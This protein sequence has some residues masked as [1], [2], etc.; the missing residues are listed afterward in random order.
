MSDDLISVPLPSLIHKIGRE[1]AAELRQLAANFG[2]ECKRI[3]RSRNWQLQ[4]DFHGLRSLLDEL[5]VRDSLTHQFALSRLSAALTKIQPPLSIEEQLQQLL[6]D[7]PNIT[8]TEMMEATSCE[9]A[10]A[11]VARFKN[12]TF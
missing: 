6:Q 2:C 3:R 7:N 10:Q 1:Q 9:I 11:R 12:D 8:L 4:G 5:Q